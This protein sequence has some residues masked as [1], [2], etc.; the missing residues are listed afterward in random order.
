MKPGFILSSWIP[1]LNDRG[2]AAVEYAL[3]ASLIVLSIVAGIANLGGTVGNH[4]NEVDA[5]VGTAGT[6][7][8]H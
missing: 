7:F 5:E 6:K 3:I 8:E 1:R 2:A 4:F